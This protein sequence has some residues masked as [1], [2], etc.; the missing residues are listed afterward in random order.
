VTTIPAFAARLLRTSGRTYAAAVVANL[1]LSRPEFATLTL[2]AAFDHPIDDLEARLQQLAASVEFDRPALIEHS[3][4]WYKVAFAHRGVPVDYLLQGFVAMQAVLG[5]EMPTATVPIVHR[6]LQNAI[7]A[8]TAGPSEFACELDLAAPHGRLAANFLLA[9]LEGRGDDAIDDLRKALAA[10][11]SLAELHDHV[12]APVQREAGRMWLMGEIPIAD[13]HHGSQVVDRALWLLHERLPRPPA[14]APVIATMSVGG[15][16]HD[17]GIRIVSQRLQM[18]GFTVLN[19]GANM[20]AADLEWMFQDR[21]I[22]LV[23]ISVA[24]A[25]H[26]HALAETVATVRR[27]AKGSVPVLVGGEP[28]RI[29][30][31]L[32]GRVGADAGAHDAEGAVGAARFLLA[33]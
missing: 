10:G 24:M 20:P 23:A 17:L 22:D 9:V 13:E 12:L 19:L 25:T 32:Y 14:D 16:L 31:D 4:R 7:D 3:A 5:E 28:F 2:P 1:R 33:R 18:A 21:R 8:A 30:P 6:H 15:N 26:L 29:V 27:A 11:V